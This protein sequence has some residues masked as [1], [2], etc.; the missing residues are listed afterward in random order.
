M[1]SFSNLKETMSQGKGG[2]AFNVFFSLCPTPRNSV[3]AITVLSAVL[4]DFNNESKKVD[5]YG[6]KVEHIYQV[7]TNID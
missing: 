1:H 6:P 3:P 5:D 4:G 7:Q 2:G